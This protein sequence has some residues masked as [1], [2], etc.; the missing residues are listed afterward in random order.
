[1]LADRLK[2]DFAP[3]GLTIGRG[4]DLR[5]VLTAAR[6]LD[7][8]GP[9]TVLHAWG[10][11]PLIA[12]ALAGCENFIYTPPT[13]L[14]RWDKRWLRWLGRRREMTVVFSRP[15]QQLDAEP[16]DLPDENCRLIQPGLARYSFA[17]DDSLR[18]Q[19]GFSSEDFVLLCTGSGSETLSLWTAAI[20]HL[21]DP[22]WRLLVWGMGESEAKLR[23]MAAP[24]HKPAML[25]IESSLEFEDLLPAADVALTL[26]TGAE[27]LLPAA[28]CM[29]AGIPVVELAKPRAT[30][31]YL[32]D[33][34]THPALRQSLSQSAH[35]D[36]VKFFD[37]DRFVEQYKSLYVEAAS[38]V[39]RQGKLL[40]AG[41]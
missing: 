38:G 26:Q 31:Q 41:C 10:T 30:A 3:T 2:N 29:A 6:S 17:R 36:A 19:L 20:L 5:D 40:V 15:S 8:F 18:Q 14:N 9:E 22:T 35:S 39:D 32:L 23:T 33:L 28:L 25:K 11:R 27:A 1:V 16:C 13:H 37:L 34:R 7:S 24:L 21:L 4:G 12:A